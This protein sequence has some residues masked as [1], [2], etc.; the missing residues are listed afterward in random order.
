M[1]TNIDRIC[2]NLGTFT[3]SR[4]LP[5]FR[6]VIQKIILSNFRIAKSVNSLTNYEPMLPQYISYILEENGKT[7]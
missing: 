1:K 7:I 3:T 2:R 6:G 4:L 5:I